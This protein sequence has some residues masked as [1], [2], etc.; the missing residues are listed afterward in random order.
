MML[1]VRYRARLRHRDRWRVAEMLREHPD[2]LCHDPG[3]DMDLW[4]HL[5]GPDD[6]VRVGDLY[7]AACEAAPCEG[8]T[9]LSCD[10]AW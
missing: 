10:S 6:L 3:R 7:Q 1:P 2:L 5:F 9:A 4:R 8:S